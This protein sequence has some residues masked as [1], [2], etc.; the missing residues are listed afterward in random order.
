MAPLPFLSV[1]LS[2]LHSNA[3]NDM[4]TRK[5]ITAVWWTQ[6]FASFKALFFKY[7]IYFFPSCSRNVFLSSNSNLIALNTSLNCKSAETH[8]LCSQIFTIMRDTLMLLFWVCSYCACVNVSPAQRFWTAEKG[9]CPGSPSN[10]HTSYILGQTIIICLHLFL[11]LVVFDKDVFI[12]NQFPVN[13]LL[14]LKQNNFQWEIN[15]NYIIHIF[16]LVNTSIFLF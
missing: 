3:R 8:L 13:L 7:P 1:C 5:H 9:I 2:L 10:N 16:Q 6:L 15:L 14:F 11:Y 12:W 4:L